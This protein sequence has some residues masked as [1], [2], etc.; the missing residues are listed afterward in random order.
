MSFSYL[1]VI[2]DFP[3][4]ISARAIRW[5]SIVDYWTAHGGQ[6]DVVCA[7][8]AGQIKSEKSKNLNIYRVNS[9]LSENLRQ[10][11]KKRRNVARP[12]ATDKSNLSQSV[13]VRN[14]LS[15]LGK[16]IYKN[17]YAKVYWPDGA[18]SWFPSALR[19]TK[20]LLGQRNYDALITVSPFFTSHLIGLRVQNE[21][22]HLN[23]L[24]DIGDPFSFEDVEPPNNR[25]LYSRLNKR[26]EQTVF[27]NADGISVTT[28]NTQEKYAELFG[29]YESKIHVIPPLLSKTDLSPHHETFF[30]NDEKIRLVY[31]GRLYKEI[32]HPDFLLRLFTGLLKTPLADRLEL[33]F[34]GEYRD[35]QDAFIPYS[36]LIGEQIFLHDQVDHNLA[37][38]VLEEGD[39]LINLGY[40]TSFRLP[41]KVVEYA[42]TGKFI[43]NIIQNK[44]DPSIAFF[45]SYPAIHTINELDRNNLQNQVSELYRFLEDQP[46]VDNAY[47]HK[48]LAPH[49]IETICESYK[50]LISRMDN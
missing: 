38:Q 29:D 42:S 19:Q 50:K 14:R 12:S 45:R 13:P 46:T 7:W 24:V 20:F 25:M 31:L 9:L 49:Q 30:L 15:V 26:I 8:Q 10:W 39:V 48:L 41:S 5:S 22:P 11:F 47:L 33:H 17:V 6:I 18:F 37:W 28:Q 43:I 36:S 23:W 32:R 3:P 21:Y 16:W 27:R 40:K 4:I 35:V 2:H 34:F 1:I 44:A